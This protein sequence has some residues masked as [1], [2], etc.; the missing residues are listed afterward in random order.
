M[1]EA[2]YTS[3]F[4]LTGNPVLSVLS[5]FT[6]RGLPVGMQLIAGRYRRRHF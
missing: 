5:G 3:P 4:N 6:S 2:A 1:H